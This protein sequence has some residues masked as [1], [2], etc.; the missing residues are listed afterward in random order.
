L[1]FCVFA[2]NRFFQFFLNVP[3][4]DRGRV[5]EECPGI[6]IELPSGKVIL[7]SIFYVLDDRWDKFPEIDKTFRTVMFDRCEIKR[8]LVDDFEPVFIYRYFLCMNRIE[9][10]QQT[11]G[12]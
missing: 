6:G 1:C 10:I 5:A 2:V 11:N 4:S 8:N 9:Q 3:Q 7:G 12:I